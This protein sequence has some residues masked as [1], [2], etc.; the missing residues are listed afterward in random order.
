MGRKPTPKKPLQDKFEVKKGKWEPREG[1]GWQ[2]KEVEN[3]PRNSAG[4]IE[5]WADTLRIWMFEMNQW[6]ETVTQKL[7]QMEARLSAEAMIPGTHEED[8]R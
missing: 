6:A 4:E 2:T 7:D 5:P 1:G 3:F 8:A